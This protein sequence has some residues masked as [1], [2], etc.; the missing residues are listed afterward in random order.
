[1][2]QSSSAFVQEQLADGR[3]LL[4]GGQDLGRLRIAEL[5]ETAP[6]NA[7]GE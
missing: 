6:E 3:V 7:V 2:G 1:M 4:G 5:G